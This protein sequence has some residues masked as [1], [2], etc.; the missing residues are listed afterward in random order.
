M[1]ENRP[2]DIVDR[3]CDELEKTLADLRSKTAALLPVRV[4]M[5]SFSAQ[6]R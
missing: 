5:L 4:L 3:K 1:L 6:Y 2:S